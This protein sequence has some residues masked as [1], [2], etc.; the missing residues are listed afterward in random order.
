[1][2]LAVGLLVTGLVIWVLLWVMGRFNAIP[3]NKG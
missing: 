3:T 1:M 2:K